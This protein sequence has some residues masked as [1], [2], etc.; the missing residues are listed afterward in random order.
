MH[1]IAWTLLVPTLVLLTSL[2]I[3]HPSSWELELPVAPSLQACPGKNRS[4]CPGNCTQHPAQRAAVANNYLTRGMKGQLFCLKAEP[5][6]GCSSCLTSSMGSAEAT[7][8][9]LSFSPY[10]ASFQP[11]S[12]ERSLMLAPR[13]SNPRSIHIALHTQ[14]VAPS[15][16]PCPFP[17]DLD[18]SNVQATLNFRHFKSQG[19]HRA[20]KGLFQRWETDAQKQTVSCPR[21]LE[22]FVMAGCTQVFVPPKLQSTLWPW[23]VWCLDQLASHGFCCLQE[24]IL[25]CQLCRS[26]LEARR[27]LAGR[28]A[29]WLAGSADLGQLWAGWASQFSPFHCLW[30]TGRKLRED[31]NHF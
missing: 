10:L 28:L 17:H 24:G 1:I 6:L 3:P 11:L 8:L 31:G 18:I 27:V 25:L 30:W 19:A 12:P 14:T 21:S 22:V 5:T 16:Q 15:L 2:Q 20:P 29:G 4:S 9:F 23:P 7:C 13:E 26:H